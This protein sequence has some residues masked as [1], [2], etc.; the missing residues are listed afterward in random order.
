MTEIQE[1][2]SRC[3]SG[4]GWAL[5]CRVLRQEDVFE[6]VDGRGVMLLLYKKG[7]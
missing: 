3:C 4:S 6:F 1:I 7:N 2:Q 5:G